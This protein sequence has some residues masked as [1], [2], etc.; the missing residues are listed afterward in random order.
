[1]VRK[2]YQDAPKYGF[3][4]IPTN[5]NTMMPGDI[6]YSTAKQG[7]YNHAALYIGKNGGRP[8]TIH[9]TLADGYIAEPMSIITSVWHYSYLNTLRYDN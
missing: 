3:K 8:M 2:Q 9:A 4:Y 7:Q 6:N 5:F 1:M